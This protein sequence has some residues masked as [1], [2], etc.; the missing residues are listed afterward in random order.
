MRA[1]PALVTLVL[2]ASGC[3][4]TRVAPPATVE[5]PVSVHLLD[6]GRH[7]SLVLPSA[8]PATWIRYSYGDW[9][10]YVERDTGFGA[11]LG[12]LLRPSPAALG[13]QVLHG[14]DFGTVLTTQIRVPIHEVL[15]LEVPRTRADRLRD[16]LEELWEREQDSR[17]EAPAWEMSFVNHPAPYTLWHNSNRMVARWLEEMDVAVSRAPILSRWALEEPASDAP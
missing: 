13:R 7:S 6:H 16:G 8:S 10:F 5:D 12:A 4:P 1:W 11:A 17:H 14:P 15:S 3:A 9:R 2:L